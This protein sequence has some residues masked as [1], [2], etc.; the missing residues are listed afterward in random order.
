MSFPHDTATLLS[1]FGYHPSIADAST[2][3]RRAQVGRLLVVGH[4][5]PD[6]ADL[7]GSLRYLPEHQPLPRG[8]YWF[9]HVAGVDVMVVQEGALPGDSV[10]AS[11]E[12]DD[13]A[14]PLLDARGWLDTLWDGSVTVPAP[15]HSVLDEVVLL[16]SGEQ[17]TVR[18]RRFSSGTWLYEVR[19]DG[20]LKS[21]TEQQLSA[22]PDLDGP[23]T[24][25]Q[26][27]PSPV[28]R[29]AA[30]LTRAK[31]ESSLSDTMFSFRATRTLFRPYQFKPVMKLL[32]TG[33][34]RLLIADE[35]G[36]G[37]TIEAGLIW[38]ELEARRAADRMLIVCPSVLVAKWR[39]EMEERFNFEVAELDSGKL[40]EF[41]ERALNGRLPSRGAYVGSLERL[42]KWEALGLMAELRV[43]F[44]LVI[45]D[46]AHYMRNV[47]T[48][49]NALGSVLSEMTDNLVFL[50]AT[51]LNL[52]SSDL[53]NLVDLLNPGEFG[54]QW[55]FDEQLEPNAILHRVSESL[56]DLSLTSEQRL[57]MLSR[58]EDLT[59][60]VPL[61]HR[62]EMDLLQEVLETA[63]VLPPES[64]VKA[65]RLLADLNAMSATITRTRKV[66]VEEDKAV[67]RPRLVQVQWSERESRFYAEYLRWC[68]ARADASGSALGFA[69]Q[70]PLR[71]AS[72]CLPAARDTVLA[73]TGPCPVVDEDGAVE[74]TSS[75]SASVAPHPELVE[76]ADA[77]GDA[78]AKFDELLDQVQQLVS[79]KRQVLLFTFSR[80][81]LEYLR[82]RLSPHARIAVL[83]GDVDKMT[84]H[85]IISDFRAGAYDMVLA[86]RV[87][88]EGLDFEFCS[89][90]INY[91]LPWNPME[92]E[93]RI[94]RIDRMGQK[95]KVILVVNFHCEET[96]DTAILEKVLDRIGVFERSI[97]PL[98]PIIRSKI[99]DLQTVMFDFTLTP[100]ERDY[101]TNQI[102]EA[103]ENE[104]ANISEL[105]DAASYLLVSDDVDVRGMESDLLRTGRYVGQAELV[106]LVSDWSLACGAAP[107][108]VAADNKTVM[109]RGNAAMARQLQQL[110]VSGQRTTA[111][112]EQLIGQLASE[113]EIHLVLDQELARTTGG[114]LLSATHPLVLAALMVPGFQQARF[115]HVAAPGGSEVPV[116]TYFVQL[117]IAEWGGL[118]PGR[119]IWGAAVD[120][121]ASEAPQAVVD[122]LLAALAMGELSD[123]PSRT[124]LP[125][126][127]ERSSMI[128]TRRQVNEEQE[129]ARETQSLLDA[130]R[131]G[132]RVQHERKLE[133][134]RARIRTARERGRDRVIPA[135][136]AQ[137]TIAN[138]RYEALME[139]LEQSSLTSLEIT[140]LAVCM[141]EVVDV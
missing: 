20:R 67:R 134:I 35:V 115:A 54:D 12:A 66:D 2:L 58:L 52:R 42:R 111:E 109:L 17:T 26:G 13:E 141:F 33:K 47:G 119:A 19:V 9:A 94:G 98:E 68:Q 39:R 3:A 128:L 28:D 130:R 105:T 18:G 62:P 123:G 97:G 131:V 6:V 80:P 78:D 27:S 116:G 34:S 102:L 88:S 77:L 56:N 125:E 69:M 63:D 140:P 29:F 108:R 129:R 138:R 132:L 72:A 36:L 23:L 22:P 117:A 1:S 43:Q 45:V 65:R 89:V 70:M 100:L 110:V 55:T 46:E 79:E 90:V 85:Q 87:A 73:W 104:S 25:A 93:Q 30:T 91:D 122:R 10:V 37:K 86:N 114:A 112:V 44:D 50:S 59:F 113:L 49:S 60:G 96:I 106:R 95:E 8:I 137:R 124:V 57:A 120:S 126:V 61:L 38:T 5:P 133:T 64:V 101:K 103:I 14:Q 83:H 92:V 81:T 74:D 84:R 32:Q 118:R 135:F 31:L 82:R 21:V 48:R 76:A 136:E 127:V 107:V 24:W 71:L 16:G 4:E 11:G 7:V 121:Q 53:Y 51:P 40:K 99:P 75:R 41:E 15:E 139:Q